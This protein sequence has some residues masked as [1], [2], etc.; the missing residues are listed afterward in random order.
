MQKL[1]TGLAASGALILFASAGQAC[2]FH[3]MHTAATK[4][5]E[6][7][8]VAMSTYDGCNAGTIESDAGCRNHLPGR[9]KGLR[10]ER[11]IAF[12]VSSPSLSNSLMKQQAPAVSRRL[13]VYGWQSPSAAD[14]DAHEADRNPA[15]FLALD[16]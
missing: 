9:R 12:R 6:Q 13:S 8:V 11:Q 15:Q 2:D 14:R 7:P 1:L 16:P 10:P 5:P 4:A 3:E